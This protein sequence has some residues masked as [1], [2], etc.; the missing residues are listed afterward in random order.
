MA[1]AGF[2]RGAVGGGEQPPAKVS[3]TTDSPPP[4]AD[5]KDMPPSFS[6]KK[7]I[8][9]NWRESIATESHDSED[10]K[11]YVVKENPHIQRIY[12]L[13][14]NKHTE[15]NCGRGS[16]KQFDCVFCVAQVG[17]VQNQT[18]PWKGNSNLKCVSA[19]L[20]LEALKTYIPVPDDYDAD[21]P[22]TLKDDNSDGLQQLDA[23]DYFFDSYC[24]MLYCEKCYPD[25]PNA[26]VAM[27]L[28]QDYVP[29]FDSSKK[30]TGDASVFYSERARVLEDLKAMK[31]SKKSE[32][33]ELMKQISIMSE[34]D[35]KLHTFSA[36]HQHREAPKAVELEII[37]VKGILE[38]IKL[39]I[40][41]LE[42]RMG[43]SAG[44]TAD[45]LA[46]RLLDNEKM[47][48]LLTKSNNC[49]D[50]MTS[51]G[52]ST[53]KT[54]LEEVVESCFEKVLKEKAGGV[55]AQK[56]A[57]DK[58]IARIMDESH[59]TFDYFTKEIPDKDGN[60]SSQ[61]EEVLHSLLSDAIDQKLAPLIASL[62]RIEGAIGISKKKEEE[63]GKGGGRG[64]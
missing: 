41:A 61:L 10:E 46:K 24:P 49:L 37:D 42:V 18:N 5:R 33:C 47:R 2:K 38:S 9:S 48:G 32:F 31:A 8:P 62:A 26:I 44:K 60:A 4:P 23:N 30:K 64:E 53:Q 21:F 29:P 19:K 28:L 51:I 16:S 3:N 15:L 39:Q 11:K 63:G 13:A 55:I 56:F 12:Q 52:Q 35:W 1:S 36:R 57:E 22:D 17:S 50:F 40:V 6:I 43:V 45:E 14:S 25:L 27:K 59:A 54:E 34:D 7:W 20:Y 58:R